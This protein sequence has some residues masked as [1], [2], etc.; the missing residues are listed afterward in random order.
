MCQEESW[1][2]KLPLNNHVI[3]VG[4]I[5]LKILLVLSGTCRGGSRGGGRTRRPAPPPKIGINMIFLALNRD[6]FTRNTPKIFAPPS[7][8]RNCFKCGPPNL[9]SWIRPWLGIYCD[10]NYNHI[11]NNCVNTDKYYL[12]LTSYI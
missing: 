9:K 11:W 10:Q 12:T 8:R 6:F 7:A 5:C 2:L 1:H 3:S 4:T